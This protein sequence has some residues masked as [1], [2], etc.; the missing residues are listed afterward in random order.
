M[1]QA[2]KASDIAR[3]EMLAGGGFNAI[4]NSM[5]EGLCPSEIGGIMAQYWY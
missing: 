3:V 2:D 1:P 4:E 5:Q